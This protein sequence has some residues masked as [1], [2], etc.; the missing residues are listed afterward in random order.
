[1][2]DQRLSSWRPGAARDTILGFLD[3]VGDVPVDQRV[4]YLDNDG[5]MWCERPR[6]VQ[7]DFFVD[8]LRQQSGEDATLAEQ[9]E[10]AAVLGND[11][12]AI[13]ELGLERVAMALARLYDGRTP[14]DFAVAVGS[15]VDRYR[16]PTLGVPL[17]GVV[18]QPMLELLDEL[19]SHD[20]TLGVVTGG[21]TEFVRCISERLY[22][23]PP[24]RV[25]GT[26]IGYEFD[27]DEQ[28]R[29]VLHRTV[30]LMSAANE[31]P[32]KVEHIQSHLGRAPLVAVGN[33][34]GDK[35]ML[36]WAMAHDRGGLA[37]LI[38]HDDADREFAYE[39]VAGTFES[40]E[41]ITA[42][43]DRLGWTTVSM[44]GDWETVFPPGGP[45]QPEPG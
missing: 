22:G 5:T 45:E 33:S 7:L 8:L 2:T 13:G 10:Y 23:V 35:E 26:L 17:D 43:A 24:E 12:A 28:D 15:F 9:P 25:V 32:A 39:S 20:F 6:Y 4:A 11:A 38:D 37:V 34:S 3:R 14:A 29:P 21:G 27:R 42:V 31:G 1:M 40:S 18:Y 41:P 16:H 44:A 36:E 30:S 19:R